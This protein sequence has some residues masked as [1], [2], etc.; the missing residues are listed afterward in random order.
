[1]FGIPWS[2]SRVLSRPQ[3]TTNWRNLHTKWVCCEISPSLPTITVN[4]WNR[5]FSAFWSGSLIV[6]GW[7]LLLYGWFEFWLLDAVVPNRA[8]VSAVS[9]TPVDN[10]SNLLDGQ[11]PSRSC[12]S[13]INSWAQICHCM[14][15]VFFEVL[16]YSHL[17]AIFTTYFPMTH[18]CSMLQLSRQTVILCY[19]RWLKN[20]CILSSVMWGHVMS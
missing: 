17:S 5:S 19:L 3:R 7:L 4:V 8:A 20:V 10:R 12:T 18:L 15:R 11:R 13:I 9:V 6:T 16:Q 2:T 14:N 1:V